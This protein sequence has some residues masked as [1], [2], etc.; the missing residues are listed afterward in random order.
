[1][2][3]SIGLVS[4]F[5]SGGLTGI[6]LG[7]SALDIQLHDTYFV[8]AHF[9]IVMGSASFFGMLAGVYHW[10]PKF[11]GRMLDYRLG[12][13]HFWFTFI[14]IYLLFTPMHYMGI[15]GIPRRYYAFTN[16]DVFSIFSDLNSFMSLTAFFIFSAQFFF[17]FNFFYSM[18]WGRIAPSNP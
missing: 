3:F 5:I 6:F 13:L 4:F 12:Q 18:F 14:G 17:F 7:N 2:L 11:F 15:A 8:V 9:H 16:F 1:M 10:Y